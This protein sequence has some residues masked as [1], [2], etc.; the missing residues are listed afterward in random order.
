MFSP[1]ALYETLV[2]IFYE[3]I[4]VLTLVDYEAQIFQYGSCTRSMSVL[5]NDT[6]PLLSDMYARNIDYT[7]IDFLI[8]LKYWILFGYYCSRI[9]ASFYEI[10]G[11]ALLAYY[12]IQ[13][14]R[15]T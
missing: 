14:G 8:F 2:L 6:P 3:Y 10:K 15:N 7:K 1:H 12:L 9:Q 13:I 4:L 11:V 5:D